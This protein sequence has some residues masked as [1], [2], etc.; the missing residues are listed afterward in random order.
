MTKAIWLLAGVLLVSGQVLPHKAQAADDPIIP[1]TEFGRSGLGVRVLPSAPPDPQSA[2]PQSPDALAC[3]NSNG[4]TAPQARIDSCSKVINSQKS[5]GKHIAWAYANRC[6]AWVKLGNLDHALA[7]CD[8]ALVQDADLAFS[9][10][11]RGD[12]Y[13]KRG[14]LDKAQ[15]DY[16]KSQALGA[17]NAGLFAKRGSVFLRKGDA[18]KALA[19]YDQEVTL[20]GGDANAWMDRGSARLSLGDDAKAQEDFAKATQLAPKDPQ[21]WFNRGAAALGAGDKAQAVE[22]LEQALKL[23][24]QNVY[25]ALWLFL[26]RDGSDQAKADLRAFTG[27]ASKKDWPFAVTQL[28]VG[29]ADAAQTLATAK[30]ADQ[31]CEARFYIGAQNLSKGA[32][33]LSKSDKDEARASLSRAVETCPKNFME[34]FRATAELKRLEAAK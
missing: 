8:E 24:P 27:K 34:F 30:G 14:E 23:D 28:Y 6:A 16:D 3:A 33:N 20:A 21:A 9:W 31:E 1:L 4:V 11:T 18:G 29:A 10:Q 32:Q 17:K 25:A 5:Q 13:G 15:D 19:D 7:D 22:S 2:A 26:A 12:I